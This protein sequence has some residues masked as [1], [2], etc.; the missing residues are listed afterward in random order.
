VKIHVSASPTTAAINVYLYDERNGRTFVA[1]PVELKFRAV[2]ETELGCLPTLQVS[3]LFWTQ[4][5][6]AIA[7][8]FSPKEDDSK[9]E[10]VLQATR[11]H[12]DDMRKLVFKE[13]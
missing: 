5:K 4:V 11:A 3:Y 10:G 2:E 6:S 1:E 7:D 12:L 9:L 13:A 8:M